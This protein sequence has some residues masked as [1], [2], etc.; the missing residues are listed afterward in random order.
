MGCDRLKRARGV[1]AAR[2]AVQLLFL[3]LFVFLTFEAAYPPLVRPPANLLLRADPIAAVMSLSAARSASTAWRFW[4]AWVL[5]A[6]SVF[7]GRFFCGW[8]CPLGTCFDAVGAIKPRALKYHRPRGGEMKELKRR[9]ESGARPVRV[10]VKFIILAAVLGLS[11]A[12]VNLLYFASPLAI[13]NRSAYYLMLP[14]FPFLFIALLLLAFFYRPRF[15]CEEICPAGALMSLASLAGRRLGAGLKP[16]AVEKDS[17]ACISCGACYRAC[18]FG[19]D[20]P[21]TMRESGLLGSYDCSRCAACVAACPAGGA[22]ALKSFGLTLARSR[23]VARKRPR[24]NAPPGPARNAGRLSVSRKEFIAS[25]GLGGMLL[26]GYSAGLRGTPE[27]LLRMPGAQD[28]SRFLATCNRCAECVRACPTGCIR[29]MGL[30]GGLQRLWT[31]RFRPRTASCVFDECN[32]ACQSVCP[33]GAILAVPP[34][35]TRIGV[36]RINR[37]TCLGYRGRPCLICQE[38][39]RFNAIEADGLR[40]VAIAENCTGCGACEQGCPTEPASIV[41]QEAGA[42]PSAG[43]GGRRRG[44]RRRGN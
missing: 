42:E 19:V 5:L 24:K 38:R 23:G 4:P 32:Q 15:W 6:L 29:M 31:P 10:R 14:G 3:V 27:P 16:L 40:P 34:E 22:L 43:G 11:F 1:R 30:E 36:A 8:L 12:G 37:R 39:C 7:C 28:E 33:A 21:Y 41:V 20:E 35:R 2:R 9:A 44:N 17:E 13:F 26:A 18:S 25:L